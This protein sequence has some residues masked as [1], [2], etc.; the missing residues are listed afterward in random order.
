[1]KQ[2]KVAQILGGD[3]VAEKR[4][5]SGASL[6]SS[7][8]SSMGHRRRGSRESLEAVQFEAGSEEVSLKLFSGN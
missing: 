2:A 1:V 7:M 3:S 4:R 5:S 8:T 6:S